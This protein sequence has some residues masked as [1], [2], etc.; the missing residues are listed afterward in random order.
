[1]KKGQWLTILAGIMLILLGWWVKT[2]LFSSPVPPGP[3]A[4]VPS[5]AVPVE[6]SQTVSPAASKERGI[7]SETEKIPLE[8]QRLNPA[9]TN[10]GGSDVSLE[11]YSYSIQREKAKELTVAPGVTVSNNAIHIKAHPDSD[12]SIEIERHPANTNNE[13]QVLW[14]SKF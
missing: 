4:E 7:P 14:K 12:K 11:D 2:V 9:K 8:P 13:Y 10:A 6:N 5:P 3:A 1:M